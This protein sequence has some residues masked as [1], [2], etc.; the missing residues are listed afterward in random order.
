MFERIRDIISDQFGI[1]KENISLETSFY[2]DLS[3][4]SLDL[5]Q[6]ITELEDEFN[7]E[8][9]NVEIMYKREAKLG[10]IISLFYSHSGENEYTITIKDEKQKNIHTIIKLYN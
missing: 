4:D 9:S 2:D 3:A 1:K 5:F 10:D 6:I 8:F 7:I